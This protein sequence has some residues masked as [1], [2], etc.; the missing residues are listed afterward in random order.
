[1]GK[2]KINRWKCS[3]AYCW[4]RGQ[5]PQYSWVESEITVLTADSILSTNGLYCEA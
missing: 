3:G 4:K 5:V 2:E 1:M